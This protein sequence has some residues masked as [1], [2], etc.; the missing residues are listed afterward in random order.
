MYITNVTYYDN[1]T[2]DYNDSLSM[3]DNCILN[4]NNI[5]II[6]PTL[7][8]TIP[9]GFSFLCLMSLM[10]YTLI[11]PLFNNKYMEKFLY[12]THPLRCIITS[13]SECGKSVIL[14]NL[15]LYII[16]EYDK[17]YIYSPSFHQDLYQKLFK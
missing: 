13:P 10:V 11:K 6:V 5:N 8:L 15:I 17:I 14:R 9:C 3:N 2:D 16:I 4:E 1:M 12:A 7:L